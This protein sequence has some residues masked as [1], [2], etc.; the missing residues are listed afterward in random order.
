MLYGLSTIGGNSA[1]V[2]GGNF[3]AAA[4][5]AMTDRK[6]S[7]IAAYDPDKALNKPLMMSQRQTDIGNT[8]PNFSL[9]LAHANNGQPSY[10]YFFD[11]VPAAQRA[12]SPYGARHGAEI[13]YVFGTG[14]MDAEGQA[15]SKTMTAYW[16]AFAKH[17]DPSK[18]GGPAWPKIDA[19]DETAMTF[20][21][22]GAK[23]EKHFLKAR[24][25]WI[26]AGIGA[27]RQ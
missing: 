19:K 18:A 21:A 27:P 20:T 5:D 16:A 2:L 9:A 24:I 3:S 25:D 13:Q 11:Y 1:D 15:L 7:F 6:D 10:L 26:L 12:T 23:A 22:T 8:E 14:V 4:F 17:G